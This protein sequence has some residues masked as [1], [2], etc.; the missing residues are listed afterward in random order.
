M[1]K[2]KPEE[3]DKFK[4]GKEKLELTDRGESPVLVG[5][6]ETEAKAKI[7]AVGFRFRITARDGV[8]FMGTR[9]YRL[10]RVNL[11][12]EKE[13]VTKAYVG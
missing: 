9:D 12:V 13:K 2:E 5:L 11:V 1:S 4:L 6:T 3:A 7:E 10:D 8:P